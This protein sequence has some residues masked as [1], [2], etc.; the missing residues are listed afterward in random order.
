MDE[1][2]IE[3]AAATIGG[4]VEDTVGS[5][6]GDTRLQ[7][8]G[9]ADQLSGRVQNAY[10]SAKDALGDGASALADQLEEFV[11]DKPLIALLSAAT[12][13]FLVARLINR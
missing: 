12:V 2:R 11:Q 3:G 6:V 5:L 13:G 10:G 8:E 1:N 4:K 9:K 7:T